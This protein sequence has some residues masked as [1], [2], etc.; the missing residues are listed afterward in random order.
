MLSDPSARTLYDRREPAGGE[1]R[2]GTGMGGRRGDDITAAVELAFQQAVTGL[3]AVVPVQRLSPCEECRA[4]GARPGSAPQ[5]C[6]HCDGIGT[7][8]TGGLSPRPAPCPLCGGTG[9]RIP[10]ACPRCRGRGVAPEPAVV[11]VSVPAGVD[12]GSEVRIPGEGHSGPFGG[13]RGDLLL[14]THV[15]DHPRFQRK[16]DNLHCEIALG[17]AEAALGARIRV[18]GVDSA[19]LDLEVPA[20]TQGGQL[21]RLRGKG[22][23]RRSGG[24]GDLYV[25]ARIEIPRDLGGRARDLLR[26]LAGALP[27]PARE[28]EVAAE[29]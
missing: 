9:A 10:D 6:A 25:A 16:G 13:P 17:L 1:A 20:G 5:R 12:T 21:F 7:V 2:A 24:R 14:A 26:E 15:H 29:P 28:R 4:T 23:P 22:M 8:W 19:W 3:E 18:R 27:P 11:R